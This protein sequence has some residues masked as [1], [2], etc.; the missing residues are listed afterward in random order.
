M[1]NERT[2]TT[3]S[4]HTARVRIISGKGLKI[5]FIEELKIK[6]LK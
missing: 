5:F 4:P 6:T 1:V 3:I 2:D